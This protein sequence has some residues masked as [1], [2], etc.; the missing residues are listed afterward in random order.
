MISEKHPINQ[1]KTWRK[2]F[3]NADCEFS[4]YV[5]LGYGKTK[6]RELFTVQARFINNNWL[7][8]QLHSLLE[9]QELALHSRIY[10]GKRLFH[11]PMIDFINAKSIEKIDFEIEHISKK[12]NSEIFYY[13]S[14]QSL[15]GYYFKFIRR[16]KLV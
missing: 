13:D 16:K 14:G 1:F 7:N 2:D 9:R 12:I 4:K 5:H 15:H 3:P 8:E 11:L 10:V 6:S